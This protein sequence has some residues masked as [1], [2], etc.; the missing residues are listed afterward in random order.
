MKIKSN[1]LVK[2]NTVLKDDSDEL[3]GDEFESPK[4]QKMHTPDIDEKRKSLAIYQSPDPKRRAK[5][6]F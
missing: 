1:E 6:K 5:K 3:Y 4:I 2:L